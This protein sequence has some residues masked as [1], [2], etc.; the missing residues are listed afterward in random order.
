MI[1]NFIKIAMRSLLK[2]KSSTFINISGLAIGLAA[3]IM[4]LMWIQHELSYDKFY[5]DYDLIYRVEQE[6]SYGEGDPYH[7]N[8]TPVPSGPV[9]KNEIAE[10]TDATRVGYLPKLLIERG[11]KKM[12]ESNFRSVD[13]T[14]FRIF[15][16]KFI[17]GEPGTALNEPHSIVITEETAKKYFG[18]E[19]PIGE[20]LTVERQMEFV[21]TGVLEDL[22]ENT[23]HDFD[24]VIP[25][26]FLYE[27]GVARDD[28]WGTNSI[29]TY[30]KLV[31][32][33]NLE[34]VGEKLTQ[35]INDHR[36]RSSSV[37]FVNPVERIRL[38]GYFGYAKPV[39]AVIYIYIFGA[40][41]IF[42]LLI[43]CINF[44]NLSTA[45][46]ANRSKEIGIKKV[47]GAQKKSIMIQFLI[48]SVF[49]VMIALIIALILVGLLIG[50][51]NT[52]AGKS[53]SVA[54]IF[55]IEYIIGY[56][57][58][59][60]LT[61][62]VAGLYPSFY[63][64]SFKPLDVLK[65]ERSGGTKS[66]KLRKVLVVV[67]FVLSVF[68]ATCGL[69]IFSQV[70][71]MRKIDVGYDKDNTIVISMMDNVKTSYS[72][73][74][75]ELE[76]HPLIEGV[77]ASRGT[78]YYL[79]SNSGGADWEGKDPERRVLIGVNWVDFDYTQTMGINIK[80]GR[81]FTKD[82]AS[83]MVTD[84]TASFLI[85]EE[86]AK[87]MGVENPVG[88]RFDFGVSGTVIG[89]MENFY[90]KPASEVIEPMVFVV[91]NPESLDFI[92]VRINENSR[93]EALAAI[94]EIWARIVPAYPLDYSFI[95]DKV[96]DMYRAE[97]RMGDLFKYFTILAILLA[98]MG[99]YGLSSFIAEQKSRE[100]GIRKVMGA[101][102]S[103]VVSRLTSE[104]LVLVSVALIIGLPLA[105]IYI[106][107]W[108][109]DFPYRSGIS[110]VVIV[111]VAL[112]SLSVA[113]IAVSF[114]SYRAG[115][116]N[117]A[118]TLRIE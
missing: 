57:I 83:D 47:S 73:I 112:I 61:G 92:A 5:T 55:R 114:Q 104:F 11:D 16:F 42:V 64:S 90:F 105:I 100:I 97:T 32:N 4:I 29:I 48:E 98:A 14:F 58:L 43:A 89:V 51:F 78:P 27:I 62:L 113:A 118:E 95:S 65:G 28:T 18:D 86:V 7:V 38:H 22:P 71:Y 106:N 26:E 50:V 3:T 1:K 49:Q 2:H 39:G 117:P 110:P 75:Q 94:E 80:Y 6:Q 52:T 37:F 91:T 72:T 116:T 45:R 63:L 99:L 44:I 77:S 19:N 17:Y 107:H 79:G 20:R 93:E 31:N 70:N 96:D 8:V 41:S 109:Q 68:L 87:L 69:V 74:K 84:S 102:V 9:W 13:S 30:V 24:G 108:L 40:I 76:R 54:D 81:S 59:A 88:L 115:K 53:F 33:A 101:S 34:L 15:D 25:Y 67:Q 36:T 66:G 35:I 23:I 85:N 111:L 10:I 46:S 21:V 103:G 12:Y 82:Y 56:L 60:L